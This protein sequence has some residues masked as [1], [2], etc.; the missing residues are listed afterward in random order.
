MKIE[1]NEQMKEIVEFFKD[2]GKVYFVGGCV[3]DLVLKDKP[4][5]YD[6]F[7]PILPDKVEEYIKS[8][9]RRAYQIGKKFGTLGVKLNG[10][11]IEIT[12]FRKELYD[13]KTRKPN[14]EYTELIEEDIRRRDFTINSLVCDFDGNIKD[15]LG[16]LDDIKSK[17][18]K[19][20]GN[21]KK[22]FKEDPLR[23][24]R[25]IRFACR[26]GYK[27]D[28]VTREKL[29]NCRWELLRISKERVIDEI[30]KI[31]QLKNLDIALNDLFHFN[32]FQVIL[33]EL[34]LQK[35]YKQWNRYHD[36]TLDEHTIKVVMAVKK[37]TNENA[38]LWCAL[39]HDIGKPFTRT[40]NKTKNYCNYINHEVL[41][42]DIT[43]RFLKYYN[44][45]NKDT[46]FIVNTINE[47]LQD[48]NWLKKYDDCCKKLKS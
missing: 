24:L 5:D 18:L 3:R 7:T 39:L 16:A 41:G 32:I 12:T 20:V 42:A 4:H 45:S 11:M 10:N 1:L 8:K 44:F 40:R 31:F 6:L 25:A 19:A 2:L 15:Y 48:D 17:T 28:E 37:E 13:S 23:I 27:Y 21:P 14:V 22:R 9:G 34:H 36:F 35:G 38:K 30:Q 47:H 43:K 29:F 33:P 46:I 26:Y